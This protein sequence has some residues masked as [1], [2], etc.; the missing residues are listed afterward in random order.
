[1]T[2]LESLMRRLG[3]AKLDKFGLALAAGNRV[4]SHNRKAMATAGEWVVGWRVE[5]SL[6]TGASTLISFDAQLEAHMAL[7][8]AGIK[9]MRA[10]TA[11]QE[12]G[13]ALMRRSEPSRAPSADDG[14]G[15][16]QT[17][18][19]IV[20]Q[21]EPVEAES[22]DAG[23]TMA[24]APSTA[25]LVA[26]TPANDDGLDDE[27]WEWM[28][29]RARAA[30]QAAVTTELP[31][32]TPAVAFK[33]DLKADNENESDDEAGEWQAA[34]ER[35]RAVAALPAE[36]IVPS[37]AASEAA[38]AAAAAP[39]TD[40]DIEIPIIVATPVY[41]MAA[42]VM[43]AATVAAAPRQR[44]A[45]G[46]EPAPYAA[47]TAPRP[48]AMPAA[49]ATATATVAAPLPAP[50]MR[51]EP[52]HLR[53]ATASQPVQ[54]HGHTARL[55]LGAI[56]PMPTSDATRRT[57]PTAT[58]VSRRNDADNDP[59]IPPP[60]LQTES[61]AP[62][63]LRPLPPLPGKSFARPQT[64]AQAPL[65]PVPRVTRLSAQ[66]PGITAIS[67]APRR[68]ASEGHRQPQPARRLATAS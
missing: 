66:L 64:N 35:A 38:P 58:M 62:R 39:I 16:V 67:P 45:A 47:T 14:G 8:A 36:P 11:R 1:M 56:P 60:R 34:M 63:L 18:A 28:M 42:V 20:M 48:L 57:R 54:L 7:P 9:P 27:E 68:A 30:D 31:V 19:L 6:V 23:Q 26:S 44:A 4:I 61:S 53:A 33:P 22:Q 50:A 43:P 59:V 25:Q 17:E 52:P 10:Q 3:Y 5:D 49:T 37:I 41:A 46:T 32:S 51:G 29:A 12:F 55:Y 65:R 24:M 2:L 21:S 13:S 15:I 40:R